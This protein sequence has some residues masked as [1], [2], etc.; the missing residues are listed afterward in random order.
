MTRLMLNNLDLLHFCKRRD[1]VRTAD[2]MRNLSLSHGAIVAM[3][4]KLIDLG[5]LERR[6]CGVN[7]LGYTYH[8]TDLGSLLLRNYA[9]MLHGYSVMAGVS[10]E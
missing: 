5:L 9:T 2:M 1:D 8:T 7:T 10:D 3:Q 4:H 6:P